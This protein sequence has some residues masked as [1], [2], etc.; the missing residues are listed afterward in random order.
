M[1]N[2]ILASKRE[3]KSGRTM[4]EVYARVN[5]NS[6]SKGEKVDKFFF[7]ES[8]PVKALRY[9]FIL[10]AKHG[11]IIPKAIYTKLMADVNASKAQAEPREQRPGRERT[12]E[13]R[14]T[15]A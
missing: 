4:W 6:E 3:F 12:K 14:H 13:E 15:Q 2:L 9:A 5:N 7:D 11:A 1:A 10:R 8:K